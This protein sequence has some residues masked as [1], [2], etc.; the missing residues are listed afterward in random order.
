[1]PDYDRMNNDDNDDPRERRRSR[2]SREPRDFDSSD[3]PRGR[4]GSRIRKEDYFT[5]N[6]TLPDYKDPASPPDGF[7]LQA[8]TLA[9]PPD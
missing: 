1:M 6:H 3:S 5:G 7:D 2:S 9:G 8:P 4:R